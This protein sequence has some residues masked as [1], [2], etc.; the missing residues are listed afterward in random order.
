MN[1]S[2]A[3][4]QREQPATRHAERVSAPERIAYEWLTQRHWDETL[5]LELANR[6]N[7]YVELDDGKVVFH[8]MPTTEHQTAVLNLAAALREYGR[9]LPNPG[10]VL[11][12]PTPIRLWPLKMREP[13]V[14]FFKAEHLDRIGTQQSGVP[15]F[16][17]EVL[18][19]STYT[20][21]TEQKMIEYALAGLPEYWIIDP[22]RRSIATYVLDGEKYRLAAEYP[23]GQQAQAQTLAGFSVNVDELWRP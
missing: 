14:M 5:Y 13:D 7:A 3:T 9:A 19:P 18:S 8:K 17:A 6:E 21:D 22:E 2:I 12:A 15:D 10:R 4:T 1:T 11:L 23:A 20:L 16:V